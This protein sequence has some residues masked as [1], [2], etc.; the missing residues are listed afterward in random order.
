MGVVCDRELLQVHC[1]M[2][3]DVSK[4]EARNV[5]IND[6]EE[7][8]KRLS[9]RDGTPWTEPTPGVQKA[10][11]ADVTTTPQVPEPRRRRS[12]PCVL[13]PT[14]QVG[15]ALDGRQGGQA[16]MLSMIA[17][18]S[19]GKPSSQDPVEPTAVT[20]TEKTSEK[21]VRKYFDRG[22]NSLTVKIV[23]PR[24]PIAE[25]ARG[26]PRSQHATIG[27]G[28]SARVPQSDPAPGLD[29]Q[30]HADNNRPPGFIS[31]VQAE[32]DAT[33]PK[34]T[35]I[36]DA[37]PC[38]SGHIT[39]SSAEKDYASGDTEKVED[40]E[41]MGEVVETPLPGY[42]S[43]GSGFSKTSNG[44]LGSDKTSDM[45]N[46]DENGTFAARSLE[47]SSNN[48]L[49]TSSPMSLKA[50]AMLDEI[51]LAPN[52]GISGTSTIRQSLQKGS[53]YRR[54]SSAGNTP[55]P[56]TQAIPKSIGS[57]IN[58]FDRSGCVV[59][60]STMNYENEPSSDGSQSNFFL[61]PGESRWT[62]RSENSWVNARRG[63]DE[64]E[65]GAAA[66]QDDCERYLGLL[67]SCGTTTESGCVGDDNSSVRGVGRDG[68]DVSEIPETS[69]EFKCGDTFEGKPGIGGMR[70]GLTW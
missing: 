23:P 63:F 51:D 58:H 1:K 6:P 12:A 69:E 64:C 24:R 19:R 25:V 47:T 3:A 61:S 38:Y 46:H 28:A 43:L 49:R 52:S 59:Y 15:D 57:T 65:T 20:S 9:L 66:A 32:I 33:D 50:Y 37:P 30:A 54:C 22:D 31:F 4:T 68:T 60:S 44:N 14:Q 18:T 40:V 45:L 7:A 41:A 26:P 29:D 13:S 21:E 56:G 70:E 34:H 17:T 27:R 10:N 36:L 16:R 67:D 53:S 35:L 11:Q 2:I 39:L 8:K 48:A 5:A 42:S 62:V 55:Y